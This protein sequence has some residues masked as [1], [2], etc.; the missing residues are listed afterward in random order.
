MQMFG[1]GVEAGIQALLATHV[2]LGLRR[3]HPA[4]AEGQVME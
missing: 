4:L 3:D 2:G 1:Q